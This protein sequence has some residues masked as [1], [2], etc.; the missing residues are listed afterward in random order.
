MNGRGGFSVA[1]G[2]DVDTE[3]LLAD[4]TAQIVL[5]TIPI[6]PGAGAGIGLVLLPISMCPSRHY[7]P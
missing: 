1:K 3:Y 2:V 6:S 5:H 4:E 7:A